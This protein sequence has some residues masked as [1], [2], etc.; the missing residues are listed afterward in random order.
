MNESKVKEQL[1]DNDKR[2]DRKDSA[3]AIGLVRAAY[4][5]AGSVMEW[6]RRRFPDPISQTD[7]R[8]MVKMILQLAQV[9]G[10]VLDDHPKREE[11]L[12]RLDIAARELELDEPEEELRLMR[13]DTRAVEKLA[14]YRLIA[15]NLLDSPSVGDMVIHELGMTE[16]KDVPVLHVLATL[17][18]ELAQLWK[19]QAGSTERAIEENQAL[20]ARY[21]IKADQERQAEGGV[22]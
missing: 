20:I 12:E 6:L 22:S 13:M 14:A 9:T 10:W 8:G 16:E 5:D 3:D 21:Q 7:L 18:N 19:R 15:A 2:V 4:E 1:M 17:T 11:W